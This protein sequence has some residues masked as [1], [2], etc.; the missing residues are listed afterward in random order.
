MDFIKLETTKGS[1]LIIR[2]SDIKS[3]IGS[4]NGSEIIVFNNES[5][6]YLVNES[7]DK[8]FRMIKNSKS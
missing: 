1:Q 7:P 8:I 4:K 3:I 6:K 5:V 2:I